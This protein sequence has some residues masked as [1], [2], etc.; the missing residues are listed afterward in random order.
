MLLVSLFKYVRYHPG[1]EI[2][3]L[4]S[5]NMNVVSPAD[6]YL[7]FSHLIKFK[8]TGKLKKYYR[9]QLYTI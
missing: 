2:Y 8:F 3:L 4:T 9:N 5:E 1:Q 7:S 6:F